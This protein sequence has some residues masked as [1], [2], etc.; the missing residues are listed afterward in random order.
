[1]CVDDTVNAQ[2]CEL[3]ALH[4]LR[5]IEARDSTAAHQ[6][7]VRMASCPGTVLVQ[8]GSESEGAL[9]LI[10]LIRQG[11]C[12]AT[13]I[14]AALTEY[15]D[16]TERAVWEAGATCCLPADVPEL[17]ERVLAEVLAKQR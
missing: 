15:D 1:V 13:V 16:G 8:V 9:A 4:D 12:R 10:R 6:A 17:M 11:A 3:A 7:V 2:L 5:V 14:I